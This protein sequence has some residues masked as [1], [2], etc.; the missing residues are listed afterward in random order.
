M[1]S[2]AHECVCG[3]ICAWLSSRLARDTVKVSIASLKVASAFPLLNRHVVGKNADL[4]L[5]YEDRVAQPSHTLH[6]LLAKRRFHCAICRKKKK[7]KKKS[8]ATLIGV[9]AKSVASD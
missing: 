3:C 7:K 5:A 6:L 4:K 9:V 1:F 8:R 2:R